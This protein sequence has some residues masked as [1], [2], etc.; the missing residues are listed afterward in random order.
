MKKR[1][2][3]CKKMKPIE[4]FR[5][6]KGY[7]GWCTSCKNE[8]NREYY[9][10]NKDK[11]AGYK[12]KARTISPIWTI[13]NCWRAALRRYPTEGAVTFK[14]LVAI[15]E[16]QDGRCALS[17]IKMTWINGT[18]IPMPTAISIDRI[19]NSKGYTKKNVRLVCF[20]VN[21]FKQ[22]MTD[23]KML[24]MAKAIVKH[25]RSK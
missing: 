22:S 5:S 23:Q 20:A 11:F 6:H 14:E 4:K 8:F 3:H 10:N 13:G 25:L 15:Y 18:K 24:E 16:A 1:C 19:N 12:L 9:K 17:G 21:T 2:F 7:T